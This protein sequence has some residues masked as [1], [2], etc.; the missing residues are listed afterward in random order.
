MTPDYR[1]SRSTERRSAVAQMFISGTTVTT[2]A[3]CRGK[4]MG[5]FFS[6]AARNKESHPRDWKTP[7][8]LPA[9]LPNRF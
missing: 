3:F 1:P 8:S 7:L 6:R 2:R 9:A 5:P 4:S